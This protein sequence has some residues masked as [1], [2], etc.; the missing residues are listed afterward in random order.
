MMS[1]P[2]IALACYDLQAQK[3]LLFMLRYT[4]YGEALSNGGLHR[5]EYRYPLQGFP[6]YLLVRSGEPVA[7]QYIRSDSWL[8]EVRVKMSYVMSIL[9]FTHRNTRRTNARVP[10]RFEHNRL[11][12]LFR[13]SREKLGED[14][15]GEGEIFELN[16]TNEF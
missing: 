12:K 11:P 10:M 3:H 6:H 1:S 7:I 15:L 4:T 8:D 16:L 9:G 14:D 5:V 13:H 2:K